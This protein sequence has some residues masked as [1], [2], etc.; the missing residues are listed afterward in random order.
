MLIRN[1]QIKNLGRRKTA[2]EAK[3]CFLFFTFSTQDG[4][5][6]A[7]ITVPSYIIILVSTTVLYQ[8]TDRELSYMQAYNQT[9]VLKTVEHNNQEFIFPTRGTLF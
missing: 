8:L 3:M 4:R 6:S 7:T 1:L 5:R 2:K 9:Q